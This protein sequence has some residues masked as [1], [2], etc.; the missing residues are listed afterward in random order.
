MATETKTRRRI[1]LYQGPKESITRDDLAELNAAGVWAFEEKHDGHWACATI[2]AG[3]VTSLTS[4]V[5][6]P[7]DAPEV[8]GARFSTAGDGM[9]V[10]ELTA[11]LV[12]GERVGERRLRIF[13]LLDWAGV[14]FRDLPLSARRT[15]LA[16]ILTE[17]DRL[18]LVAHRTRGAVAFYDA[19]VARGGEGVVAKRL[20]STYRPKNADGKVHTW[21]RCK[22]VHTVD[23]IVMGHGR[24]KATSTQPGGTVNL[25]VGL[26][27]GGQVVRVQDCAVPAFL[28]GSNLD[29]LTGRV[30]EVFGAEVFPS[31]AVR[32]GRISRLRDDK[33]PEDCTLESARCAAPIS[34]SNPRK[35]YGAKLDDAALARCRAAAT[36]TATALS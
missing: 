22:P 1:S 4:R 20:D 9:I 35:L 14:D 17:T 3:V 21:V 31:G 28:R 23:V 6:L 7:L 30:V 27:R 13:D 11:D 19:I 33:A 2:V 26:I 5:G 15:V 32:H 29:L 16:A 34:P 10:G 24:A 25:L 8:I 36:S 12:D 18:T